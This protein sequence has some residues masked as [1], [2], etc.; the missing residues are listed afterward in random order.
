MP[1]ILR[2][3]ETIYATP[4]ITAPLLL[5]Y[6]GIYYNDIQEIVKHI[7]VKDQGNRLLHEHYEILYLDDQKGIQG[8]DVKVIKEAI[9]MTEGETK[10]Q[11]TVVVYPHFPV[12]I[13]IFI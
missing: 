7:L 9:T 10:T 12:D 6:T 2:I 4:S 8:E 13:A 1:D 11:F 3:I 5:K